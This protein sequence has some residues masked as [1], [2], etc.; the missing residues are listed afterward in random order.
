MDLYSSGG[1]QTA[2]KIFSSR[3]GSRKGWRQGHLEEQ[4]GGQVVWG[5]LGR[6]HLQRLDET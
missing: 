4:D 1:K 2:Y 5:L 3:V 6:R